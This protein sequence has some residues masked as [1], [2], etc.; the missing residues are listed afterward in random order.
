MLMPE[1]LMFPT[2][3]LRP[4][5]AS[6]PFQSTFD[7]DG[8]AGTIRFGAMQ[9]LD[10]LRVFLDQSVGS[11]DD[12]IGAEDFLRFDKETRELIGGMFMI[13]I[14]D[15]TLGDL[16]SLRK[17]AAPAQNYALH[18]PSLEVPKCRFAYLD[19]DNKA[20]LCTIDK[21][22][23]GL[24]KAALFCLG[25]GFDLLFQGDVYKG[26]LV[27]DP[28]KRLARGDH[29]T[30]VADYR[31]LAALLWPHHDTI[32]AHVLDDDD[33]MLE[34]YYKGLKATFVHYFAQESPQSA[35]MR[36]AVDDALDWF[37]N[38]RS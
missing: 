35:L 13:P 29:A 26:Y 19:P 15:L 20:L 12:G 11:G 21:S 36:R 3:A 24:D 31:A 38:C 18:G 2:G 34:A 23:A 7:L 9:E 8:F 14:N 28:L 30:T 33:Q 22:I 1:N 10:S 37:S 32:Y 4:C 17:V 16:S 6:K 5:G 25:V 27:T